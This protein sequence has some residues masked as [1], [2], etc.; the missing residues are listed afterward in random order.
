MKEGQH[1]LRDGI[2]IV[3]RR[4]TTDTP[5][6]RV[7]VVHGLGEHSGRWTHVAE[8]FNEQGYEVHSYDLRGHGVSGGR[9]LDLEHF[10]QHIGDLAE[11]AG[12]VDGGELPFVIYGHSM[13]GLISTG[14]AQSSHQQPDLYVLSAPALG[15][16][17]PGALRAAVNVLAK[18]AP[19]T[20]LPASIKSEHLSKDP[21]VGAA[22]FDDPRVY[23]KGTARAGNAFLSAMDTISAN[24]QAI[25]V[26]ALVV[27]GGDDELVPT[28][29]SAPL[30]AVPGV[31]R[32]VFPTLRH[33][34]HNEAERD[35]VLTFIADWIDSNL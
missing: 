3:T 34:I 28:A 21:A 15:A 12:N 23:L 7:L 22:Y 26:P 29:V 9:K 31:T 19:S 30:A 18:V 25:S 32:R 10:D 14:F 4:W 8:F 16:T 5:R 20:R 13:G 35:E 2:P 11:I 6:A 27:H 24:L 17:V 1:T 33:E